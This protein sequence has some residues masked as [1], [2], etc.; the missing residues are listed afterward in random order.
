ML[1]EEIKFSKH[2]GRPFEWTNQLREAVAALSGQKKDDF[3]TNRKSEPKRKLYFRDSG[4]ASWHDLISRLYMLPLGAAIINLWASHFCS[5]ITPSC[6]LQLMAS[7][8][9][10]VD[11]AE[12]LKTQANEEFRLKNYTQANSLYEQALERC[13]EDA[14]SLRSVLLNNLAATLQHLTE[15]AT[16]EE[17]RNRMIALCTESLELNP[18]YVKPLRRRAHLYREIGG[19]KLDNSLA[20]YKRILE[21]DPSDREAPREIVE[22]ESEIQVRNEKLKDEMVSKLKDLGNLVLKPFG[23]STNNFALNPNESGGY[24]V[25]FEP[26]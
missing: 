20:D 16:S 12:S 14:K 18:E 23:L 15:D 22:L 19:E 9:P 5:I 21:L 3:A 25:N 8:Q 7:L 17:D 10:S 1:N 2:G 24:S 6:Q 11:E 4:F 13:P 26:N